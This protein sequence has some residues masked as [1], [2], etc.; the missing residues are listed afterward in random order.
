M[1]YRKIIETVSLGSL[2]LGARTTY[3]IRRRRLWLE[4]IL[5]RLFI[6]TAS[7]PAVTAQSPERAFTAVKNLTLDVNDGSSRQM[8]RARG[9]SL[10]EQAWRE[11][12]QPDGETLGEVGRTMAVSETD[13]AH[14]VPL[15]IVPPWA[16]DPLGSFLAIPLAAL[17][18]DPVLGIDLAPGL[19]ILTTGS[20][21]NIASIVVELEFHF[22]DVVGDNPLYFPQEIVTNRRNWTG[23]KQEYEVPGSGFLGSILAQDWS[24]GG[25]RASGQ[26]ATT[27][28]W[29][30]Y[31]GQT[32]VHRGTVRGLSCSSEGGTGS[33]YGHASANGNLWKDASW[34]RDFLRDRSFAGA[35]NAAS[36]LNLNGISEGGDKCRVEASNTV[37]TAYTMFTH[38]KLLA[39]DLSK[40]LGV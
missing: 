6:T 25:T 10:I 39:R 24:S 26:N 9:T 1:N 40:L 14:T 3:T 7:S 4:G 11:G 38:R 19:E 36:A 12:W 34:F 33:F 15:W 8:C 37:N 22:R 16:E 29:S 31:Y 23:G 17:N 18:E 30:I 32:V 13:K 27:D 28:E 5:T 35:F 20:T 2:P 21:T